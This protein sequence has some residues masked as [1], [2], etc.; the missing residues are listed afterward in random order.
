MGCRYGTKYAKATEN[1]LMHWYYCCDDTA[2]EALW[3]CRLYGWVTRFVALRVRNRE[4]VEDIAMNVAFKILRTKHR[5]TLRFC[6]QKGELRSWIVKIAGNEISD[7]IRKQKLVTFF[8]VLMRLSES[9]EEEAADI[10]EIQFADDPSE[11]L[12]KRIWIQEAVQKLG[13][14]SRTIVLLYFWEE[15]TQEEI[16]KELGISVATVNRK[17]KRDLA[18][19]REILT[20]MKNSDKL[21]RNNR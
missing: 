1:E 6:S 7:H 10:N 17:L 5:P 2:F 18:C 16:S 21:C 3:W 8:S 11:R 12:I 9:T 4:D 19:L 20:R 14:P 15:F 13:E